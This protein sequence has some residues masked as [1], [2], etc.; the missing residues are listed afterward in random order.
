MESM[1]DKRQILLLALLASLGMAGT[2]RA[3]IDD[4]SALALMKKG[5]CAV[6]HTLDKKLLGPPYK[7]V[8]AKRRADH[9]P[10]ATLTNAVRTG[11]KGGVYGPIPMPVTPPSK[12][13]DA[14]L[15]SLISWILTK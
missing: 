2:A 13:S 5:G 6:C 4:A 9:T 3:A 1:K 11:S 7:V 12:I 8:G 15:Q 14:E 10:V